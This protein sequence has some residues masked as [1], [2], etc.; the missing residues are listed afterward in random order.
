MQKHKDRKVVDYSFIPPITTIFNIVTH[1][2][3]PEAVEEKIY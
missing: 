3:T 1:K 2:N